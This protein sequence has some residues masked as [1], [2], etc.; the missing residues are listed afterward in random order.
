M[1][2]P[3][4]STELTYIERIDRVRAHIR[5]H[6]D[7]PLDLDRLAD[8]A[9][10]SRFHWHRVYRAMTGETAT[11]TV[12]RMRLIRAASDLIRTTD[13]VARIASA[14]GYA[15]QAAFSRAFAD[16]YG[17]PPRTFRDVGHH[18]ELSVAISEN[19]AMAFTVDIR[20]IAERP[21][22]A[23]VHAGPYREIGSTFDRLFMTL[24]QKGLTGNVTGMTGV[25]AD[26]PH[27]VS[28]EDLRSYAAAFVD[29]AGLE[30][31]DLIAMTLGGG[32]Y[33]VL[34][35]QGPYAAIQPA[36]DWLYGTWLPQSGQIARDAPCLEINLNSPTEVAP[37]DL[38][39][40]ICL[41]IERA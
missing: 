13:P 37:A 36:Y 26:D 15:S 2:D 20:T 14:A 30:T 12:R 18:K 17:M 27:I 29:T 22:L 39:T 3:I 33:A 35:Y 6:L 9:C 4:A 40:E 28:P 11:Q 10:Y 32:V 21:A 24:S 7:Q 16:A 5:D 41:P 38:L 1:S 8:I 31:G 25:Y 19:D 34:T 23:L